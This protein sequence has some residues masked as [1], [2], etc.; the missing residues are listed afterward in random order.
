MRPA[1]TAC[2]DLAATRCPDGLR[3]EVEELAELIAAGRT[4]SGELRRRVE[5]AGPLVVLE[6]EAHA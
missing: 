3:R 2:A 6:E 5:A 1:V 4:P